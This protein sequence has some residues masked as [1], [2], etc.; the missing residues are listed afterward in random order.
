MHNRYCVSGRFELRTTTCGT[1]VIKCI[2]LSI[3]FSAANT[4]ETDMELF[5]TKTGHEF[6]DFTL[7]L[8]GESIQTHMSIM[9]SRCAYFECMFRSM[10]PENKTTEVGRKIHDYMLFIG[11]TLNDI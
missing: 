6:C 9:A 8:D 11:S 10:M 7:M 1:G 2:K 4:L 3:S 5:L